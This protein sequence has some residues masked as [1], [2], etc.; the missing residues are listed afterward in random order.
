Q[1]VRRTGYADFWERYRRDV[2]PKETKNYVPIILAMTIMSKNPAQYG[3]DTLQAESP[4]Q[5]DVVRVDYPVDLRLAAV[6][7]ESPVE[8]VVALNPSLVRRTTPKDQ[9]FDL[10]LPSGTR[11]KY[12]A[13]TAAIPKD[14]RVAWR[15]HKVQPGD[16][17]AGIAKKYRTTERSIAQ[18]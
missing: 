11:D 15:Y 1:A 13:A 7:V 12:Q 10:H 5:Y 9:S 8:E 3:L 4:E 16:T 18:A 14:K 2:L 6:C 17:L